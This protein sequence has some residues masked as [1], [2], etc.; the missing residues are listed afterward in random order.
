M[1]NLLLIPSVLLLLSACSTIHQPVAS[2]PLVEQNFS[3]EFQL[4]PENTWHSLATMSVGQSIDLGS[5]QANLGKLFFAATGKKC[6]QL[7]FANDLL[8]IACLSDGKQEW[9][10]VKPVISEY[11]SSASVSETY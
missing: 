10:L 2:R 7:V 5:K 3:N 9:Y 4:L 6:R 8:R 1:K 11:I